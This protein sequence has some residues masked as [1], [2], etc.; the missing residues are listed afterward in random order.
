D[1]FLI[2]EL[3]KNVDGYRISSF[4]HKDREDRGNK[5][6]AGPLWDYNLGFGN[7][8]YYDGA[9]VTGWFYNSSYLSGDY[10]QVPF[11]W[12]RFLQD[13]FYRQVMAE[14]Y[15]SFRQ[16][17]LKTETIHTYIDSFVN[18]LQQAQVRNY[19]K[20]PILGT[21]TWPNPFIGAT[22]QQE[23]DYMKTWI[24]DRLNWMD[25]NIPYLLILDNPELN[26]QITDELAVIYP[27]PFHAYLNI[28]IFADNQAREASVTIHDMTGR[29]LFK[30]QVNLN[31][32]E[33]TY[34]SLS[35]RW[36]GV[37]QLSTGVYLIGIKLD[38]GKEFQAKIIKK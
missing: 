29:Q 23:I 6:V 9:S 7:A 25:V 16:N 28:E 14:R 15:N 4:F 21:Y 22:Y 24:S 8:D 19:Q 3:S 12:E 17:I 1:Y 26:R 20:W 27:N 11:W 36:E 33:K 35:E 30:D 13:P 34:Y 18:V 38:S 32:R 5:I 2:N 31:F 10:W 37:A